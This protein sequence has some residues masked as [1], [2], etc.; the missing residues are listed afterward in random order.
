MAFHLIQT[1]GQFLCWSIRVC[2]IWLHIT[3]LSL[4]FPLVQ[5]H[6]LTCCSLNGWPGELLLWASV[7]VSLHGLPFPHMAHS[8]TFFSG[9]HSISTA[10]C[11]FSW[12]PC[13]MLQSSHSHNS[14]YSLFCCFLPFLTNLTTVQYSSSSFLVASLGISRYS[15]DIICKQ[16]QFY[17]F[18]NLNSFSFSSVIAVSKTSKI[19]MLDKSGTSCHP[20][21][22]PDL[23][24]KCFQ[25]FTLDYDVNCGF[26]VNGLFLCWGM[27]LLCPLSEEKS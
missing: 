19:T 15:T 14:F 20:Y 26:I 10:H 16:W 13:L 27:F 6:W 17:F 21:L 2:V 4:S 7:F 8:L 12:S 1:R 22:V 3:S 11:G 18:S 5:P 9:P 25:L 24:E 23:I